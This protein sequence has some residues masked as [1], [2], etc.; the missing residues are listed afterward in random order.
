MKISITGHTK[1]IGKA[2]FDILSEKHEVFGFS[3]SNGYDINQPEK[4]FLESKDNNV[5]INNAFSSISQS[6]LF[7]MFFREWE[8]SH[9]TIINIV[10]KTMYLTKMRL[11]S[12]PSPGSL[13]YAGDKKHLEH[14]VDTHVF[15]NQFKKCRVININPGYVDTEMMPKSAKKVGYES[16]SPEKISEVVKWALDQP[17][18]IEIYDL[19]IWKTS[20]GEIER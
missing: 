6:I 11:L 9:K 2:C 1:G 14:V 8:G 3:R 7:D 10:S 19:S 17:Q 18:D 15:S 5:F 13:L 12:V 20:V 16:L 4:I